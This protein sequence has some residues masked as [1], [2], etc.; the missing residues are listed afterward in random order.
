MAH[1]KRT[2]NRLK[3][4]SFILV[5]MLPLQLGLAMWFGART[6]RQDA[7]SW[8]PLLFFFVLLPAVDFAVGLYRGNVPPGQERE[9]DAD[10]WLRGL[11]LAVLPVHFAMLAWSTHWFSTQPLGVAGVAGWL[12]SQGVISG[13]LA[14]NT[15]HELVHKNARIERGA[16]ALLLVS[17]GYHGF[18]I[19]HIRGHH[20]HVSTPEDPSSARFGQSLWHFL[21]RALWR[22]SANA[23]RLEAARLRVSG[24]P[25]FSRHNEMLMLTGLWLAAAAAFFAV[26]G[27][28]GGLF[29][30]SQGIL[31]ATTLEVINYVEHYGLE[32]RRDGQGRYERTT[33][34]H[35]W[36]SSFALSNA[37]LFNLQR[38]SDHH[39]YPKRRYGILR[40]FDDSPQLPAG[41]PTMFLLAL[42]PPLWFAVM[43]ARVPNPV[44]VRAA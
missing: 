36:N 7:W 12:L 6:G 15:A 18:K 43:D 26:F 29:F 2:M 31:A 20:V 23:W 37:M 10:R 3:A 35:S 16:G 9:V 5:F 4:L 1:G 33:H 42:C 22:N 25:A 19:E 17:V 40:H 28:K 14:I 30:L 38:H 44:A 32:R 34:R 41:Y 8:Y 11:C 39:A 21:P 27:T 24:L 13:A